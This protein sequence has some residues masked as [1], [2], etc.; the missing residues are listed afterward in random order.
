MQTNLDLA[1]AILETELTHAFHGGVSPS[2]I[3]RA[4]NLLQAVQEVPHNRMGNLLN[5]YI[6][7]KVN[8]QKDIDRIAAKYHVAG[9]DV[10][11]VMH[12]IGYFD[13]DE[14]IDMYEYVE[15]GDS[16]V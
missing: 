9:K 3:Q 7:Q 5:D 1:K 10:L 15:H 16:N 2:A 8:S 6:F 4:L 13:Y 11:N 14:Q 12:G